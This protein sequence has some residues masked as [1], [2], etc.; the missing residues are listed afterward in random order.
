MSDLDMSESAYS[1]LVRVMEDEKKEEREFENKFYGEGEYLNYLDVVKDY[2]SDDNSEDWTRELDEM[3]TFVYGTVKELSLYESQTATIKYKDNYLQFTELHGQGCL[4]MIVPV[5]YN[6]IDSGIVDF[7]DIVLYH[8]TGAKPLYL[9]VLEIVK[10]SLDTLG[11]ALDKDN[12]KVNGK[13]FK[14][15]EVF[16]YLVDSIDRDKNQ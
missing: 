10:R 6:D 16:D 14:L 8:K 2:M 1:N 7:Q 3:F 13:V 9:N 5:K 15:D 4:R 12:I 11:T